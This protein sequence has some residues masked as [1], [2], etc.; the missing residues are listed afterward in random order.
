MAQYF[1]EYGIDPNWDWDCEAVVEKTCEAFESHE[2]Y[3]FDLFY[4]SDDLRVLVAHDEETLNANREWAESFAK[5]K[6]AEIGYF[7]NYMNRDVCLV[8]VEK[9]KITRQS[10]LQQRTRNHR[11]KA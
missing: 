3:G 8:P 4:E 11:K 9:R 7:A 6:D 2:M 10:F 1:R 5:D